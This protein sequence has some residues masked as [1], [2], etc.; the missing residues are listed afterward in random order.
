[1]ILHYYLKDATKIVFIKLIKKTIE[2]NN[3]KKCK[4]YS[5]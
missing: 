3:G 4:I 2:A 5:I 1:M